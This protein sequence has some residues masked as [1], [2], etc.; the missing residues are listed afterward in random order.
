M[1]TAF[2]SWL[3]VGICVDFIFLSFVFVGFPDD[4]AGEVSVREPGLG[5]KH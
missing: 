4:G 2:K 1:D 3:S 5:K